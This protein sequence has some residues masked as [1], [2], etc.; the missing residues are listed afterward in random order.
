MKHQFIDEHLGQYSVN[1]MCQVLGVS[2]SGYY[3]AR[4][5]PPSERSERQGWLTA[6][7]RAIHQASRYSYG[8]PR[9]HAELRAQGVHCCRN[10][11]AKLMRRAQIVPKAVRRF[12]LTTDSRHTCASPNLLD[13][14]FR[15]ER[16]NA[17]WLSDV[18]SIS[19]REGWLYLAV[20][21][22]LYSR[23]VVGWS[24]GRAVDCKLTIDALTMAIRQRGSA[25]AV[26]HSDQG[27][28]YAAAD[29]R[30]LLQRYGIRQSMSRKA[31]CW[32]NAPM[33][34]FFHT[35]KTELVMHEDYRT[36]DQARASI[37]DYMEVFYNRQRRHSSISYEAPLAFETQ[38]SPN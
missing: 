13:R 31:D 24:M 6:C 36:R 8:A 12:R 11:V 28:T 38:Q 1:R 2:R 27:S 18:T 21:L 22:D 33:E 35:L 5:R 30:A 34:S 20:I 7:I 4:G 15:A 37:F 14:V 9:V 32:D 23:A 10:T 16:T 26:L 25:P 17:C 29:Y 19:T 3:A